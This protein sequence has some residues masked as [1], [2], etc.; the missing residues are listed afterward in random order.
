V[1]SLYERITGLGLDEPADKIAIHG[2]VAIVFEVQRGKVTG[3]EAATL[4][5]LTQEQA[6]QV[7]TFIS[8][9]QAAPDKLGF[10]RIF[11][12]CAY[13]AELGLAYTTQQDFIARLQDA[14]TDQGGTVP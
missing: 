1:A 5:D 7:Q 12:D 10:M 3:A 2:F 11:K 6:T 14:I 13:L 4:F 9:V 8:Y